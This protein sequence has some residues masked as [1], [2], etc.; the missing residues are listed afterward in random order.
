MIKQLVRSAQAVMAVLRVA[1]GVML[2]GSVAVNFANIIGRYFL[3]VSIPWAEEVM[4]FLMIACVFLHCGLVGWSGRQIRMD[5]LVSLLPPRPRAIMELVGEIVVMATGLLVAILAW[6]VVSMLAE[7][8]E[9]SEGANIPL[10][11]PQGVMPIGFL[12]MA[13]LIAVRLIARRGGDGDPL[14]GRSD[15]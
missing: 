11:L 3:A 4:L 7:L 15:H 13:F 9:R 12:I 10:V 1:S 6:P 2:I 8:D 14:A 5:A